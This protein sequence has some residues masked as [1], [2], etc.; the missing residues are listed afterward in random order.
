LAGSAF[1]DGDTV[2]LVKKAFTPIL[3]DGD[4]PEND[5]FGPKYGLSYYPSIVF[6]DMQGNS[7]RTI[8]GAEESTFEA[9][10]LELAK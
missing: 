10:V 8:N 6:A 7:I 2:A 5:G 3:V 9:A 4:D 1:Q